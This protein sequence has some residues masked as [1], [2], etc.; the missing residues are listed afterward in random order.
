MGNILAPPGMP[1][2][3][4]RVPEAYVRSEIASFPLASIEAFRS[5]LVELDPSLDGK[6]A[7]QT[8]LLWSACEKQ[9]AQHASGWSLDR[10]II[11]R[12]FFWFGCGPGALRNTARG[13]LSMS[14]YL[15]DLTR[16]YLDAYPGTTVLNQSYE[17]NAFDAYTHYRWLTFALPEDLLLASVPVEAPPTQVNVEYPLL[18]QDLADRGAAEVHHHVG[19]GMDF[20]LLWAS[21]LA[22]LAD[23]TLPPDAADSPDLPF[24]MGERLL[25]WLVASA[26]TRCVLTEFLLQDSCSGGG[27][28]DFLERLYRSSSWPYARSKLLH[29]T[30]EALSWGRIEQLPG[31]YALQG[32]Y[33]SLH[34]AAARLN[35]RRPE[36]VDAVWRCCDPIAV[37]LGLSNPNGGERWLL[38]HGLDYLEHERGR[39]S[40]DASYQYF[41]KLFWQVQRVRCIYYR[42]VVQR[43]LTA[44]LQWFVRFYDR[45]WWAREPLRA[46]RAEVSYQV[47]GRGRPL[48]SLEVRTSPRDDP[49]ALAEELHELTLSWTKVLEKRHNSR[50]GA[51]AP[52]FGVLIHFLRERDAEKRW[53]AG[54]PPAAEL[55]THAE[56]RAQRGPHLGG[57]FANFFSDQSVK[58]RAIA[59][60]LEAVP[61]ALWLVRGLD[62]ASDE[63]GVPTWVLVPLYRFIHRKAT[64]A[65]M[66]PAAGG[67]PPLRL[68]AHV[69][70]DFRHLMEGLRHIF[71]CIQ[72][73]L[74]RFGGRLGHATALGVEPRLWAE[75]TGSVMMTAEARMWD[76]VFEWRM[77]SSY[78][79]APQ[80]LAQAPPGRPEHV[81]NL[82]REH[83]ICM[84]GTCHE[85]QVM[86]EV[87]H[88]LHRLLCQPESMSD[89]E[90]GGLDAFTRALESLNTHKVRYA[91]QVFKILRAYREDEGTF[92]RGQKLVDITLDASEVA[93]L[94]A[95]QGALRRGVSTR[96]LVIEVNPSSNLLVGDLLDLRNHPIL[97]LFPPERQEG[98]PPPVP[99]AVGSDDPITFSTWLLHEYSLLYEAALTA[100][101]P[102]RVVH[103]W[104]EN[105][106]KTGMNARFTLAWQPTAHE[107]ADAL[108]RA[109]ESYLLRPT[110]R[111]SH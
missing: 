31:F 84:F 104:L 86:A 106:Q 74:E 45:L 63:L 49:F 12:D 32:L 27:L 73:L 46:T 3:P 79:I 41:N 47:A 62:V 48:S 25:R 90:A 6:Q 2:A 9:L 35:T 52:E 42:T 82:I 87:H 91:E 13:P 5:A 33:G 68:T 44:G 24:G 59:E 75:S 11:T 70:E 109:F 15:R 77:Y 1:L 103:T 100:G 78:R 102:E 83:T 20:P 28:M 38:R 54:A 37:R 60:L 50:H 51:R 56:P 76:L 97:R 107:R 110:S 21:L 66:S 88:I 65:S 72:Y 71:E 40:Q 39:S 99:I 23:P 10:L 101:Y 17:V 80:F 85:P 43:P 105:I 29:E 34:P 16:D 93:A 26:V 64:L 22:R 18:L 67:A 57:R 8:R 14:H 98:E 36:T 53:A 95:V 7:E 69:G 81:E 30:L 55:G 108:L 89:S 58:A 61:Q 4:R 92:R 111:R 96:N 94:Q 19:A